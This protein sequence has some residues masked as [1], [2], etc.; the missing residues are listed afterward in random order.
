MGLV[1]LLDPALEPGKTYFYHI[2]TVPTGDPTRDWS[3][4]VSATT[5]ADSPARPTLT[6]EADGEN[7]IDLTWTAPDSGGN[8]IVRYEL[9]SWNTDDREWTPVTS[10]LSATSTSYK[11]TGLD[12]RLLAASIACVP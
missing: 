1:H 4:V 3:D 9:E 7:A 5:I 6:A 11:H 8:A 10:A 12:R 2:Q